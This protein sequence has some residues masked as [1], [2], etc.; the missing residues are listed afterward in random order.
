MRI[1]GKQLSFPD[2]FPSIPIGLCFFKKVLFRKTLA[3]AV[4]RGMSRLAVKV[5]AYTKFLVLTIILSITRVYM[6]SPVYIYL[7]VPN[8][9]LEARELGTTREWVTVSG[10]HLKTKFQSVICSPVATGEVGTTRD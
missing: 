9:L 5:S 10:I 1:D 8:S 6:Q 7:A 4:P 2:N 3:A